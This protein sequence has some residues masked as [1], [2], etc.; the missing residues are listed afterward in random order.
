M[1]FS[2]ETSAS[3][4]SIP[5][6]LNSRQKKYGQGKRII[7]NSH[8]SLLLIIITYI[9]T[10]SSYFHRDLIPEEEGPQYPEFTRDKNPLQI[11]PRIWSCQKGKCVRRLIEHD[12]SKQNSSNDD[13]DSR[14]VCRVLFNITYKRFY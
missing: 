10:S 6:S 5:F 7:S 2:I 4:H 3:H 11:R 12:N 8:W 1:K 13:I 9:G 14:L